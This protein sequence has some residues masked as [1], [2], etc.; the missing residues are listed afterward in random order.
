MS[1]V[2]WGAYNFTFFIDRLILKLE[3]F[4]FGLFFFLL[5]HSL[6]RFPV[7]EMKNLLIGSRGDPKSI[8]V[9]IS[10]KG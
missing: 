2:K 5:H 9:N 10:K 4:S 7:N 8:L 1:D 3:H 6:S